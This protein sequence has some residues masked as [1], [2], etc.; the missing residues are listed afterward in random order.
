VKREAT[1]S[2]PDVKREATNSVPD[3]KR[4]ATN[5]VPDVKREASNSVPSSLATSIFGDFRLAMGGTL[6]YMLTSDCMLSQ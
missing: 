4:E 2:V 6:H 3:V 1:N 5:S